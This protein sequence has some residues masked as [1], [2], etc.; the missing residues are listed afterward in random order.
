MRL[1]DCLF[2]SLWRSICD[3]IVTFLLITIIL[4]HLLYVIFQ[5]LLVLITGSL[6]LITRLTLLYI[7]AETSTIFS[8]KVSAQERTLEINDQQKFSSNYWAIASLLPINIFYDMSCMW[9]TGSFHEISIVAALVRAIHC[10]PYC[11]GHRWL[12]FDTNYLILNLISNSYVTF[13]FS[14]GN[15][16]DPSH[17]LHRPLTI[18]TMFWPLRQFLTCDSSSLWIK[19]KKPA[20]I[21]QNQF[22]ASLLCSLDNVKTKKCLWYRISTWIW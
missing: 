1:R 4:T 15:S 18:S 13:Q 16:A 21:T 12:T 11:K 5:K 8:S 22:L 7:H 6:A 19:A 20:S 2:S 10:G 17:Y 9:V 14:C 3:S